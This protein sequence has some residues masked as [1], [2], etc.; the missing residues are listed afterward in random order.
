MSKRPAGHSRPEAMSS[1]EIL[2]QPGTR[3]A[4]FSNNTEGRGMS[5]VSLHGL[6]GSQQWGQSSQQ[7][8]FNLKLYLPHCTRRL[9]PSLLQIDANTW[10]FFFFLKARG[11]FRLSK[12]SFCIKQAVELQ[13]PTV[14]C[15]TTVMP[16]TS[17][18]TLWLTKDQTL[19]RK[20]QQLESAS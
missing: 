13:P 8:H 1:G 19:L 2:H 6:N 20:L 17:V 3:D 11:T 7:Q 14:L 5:R 4:W 18:V 9:H 10:I 12:L 15:W 16:L